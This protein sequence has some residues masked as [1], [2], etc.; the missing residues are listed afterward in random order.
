VTNLL[1]GNGVNIKHGGYSFG[2]ADIVLRGLKSLESDDFP[3]H[4]IMD[5]PIWVKYF[6]GH[7]FV[8]ILNTLSGANDRY[9]VL[10]IEKES[11]VEFKQKYNGTKSLKMTDIGFEDYYL[12]YD[13]ICNKNGIGNPERYNIRTIIQLTFLNSIYNN[14]NVNVVYKA[15]SKGFIQWLRKHE[16]IFTTNY[17]R[18]IELA[19]GKSV[20]HLH[21]DFDTLED[22]YQKDS[23]RNSLP[24]NPYEKTQVDVDFL[25]LYSTAITTYSGNYK[26]YLMNLSSVANEGIDKL[27]DAYLNNPD[28]TKDVDS[29]G[30]DVDNLVARLDAAVKLRIENPNLKFQEVYPFQQLADMTG[31]L[32]II[33]LSPFNDRHLFA[34][35]NDSEV[36]ECTFY[37]YD[38]KK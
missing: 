34:V 21:G 5:E 19:T 22:V 31:K 30:D 23:F 4:I 26:Q 32:S 7:L 17:D 6:L 28:V 29:W 2:N 25:H 12:I 35:I 37:Y 11:L 20:Y 3:K 1:V 38:K 14:G 36:S 18:N 10:A 8:E 13:I 27:V 9:A 33:G 16:K 24:D 15:F